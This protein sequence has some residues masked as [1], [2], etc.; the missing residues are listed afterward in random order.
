[1]TIKV[2]YLFVIWFNYM[3]TGKQ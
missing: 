3:H 1:L 2:N